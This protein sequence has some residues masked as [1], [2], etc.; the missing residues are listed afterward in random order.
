[1][2]QTTCA[3]AV[4]HDGKILVALPTNGSYRH[5]W[6][7]P[8]GIMD[9]GETHAQA[10]LRECWEETG[11]DFRDREAELID[12]GLHAYRPHKD[13]HLSV[14]HVDAPIDTKTCVCES[15]FIHNEKEYPE[16]SHFAF[17][18]IDIAVKDYL[19]RGQSLLV[20]KLILNSEKV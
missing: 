12:L 2:K 17:V 18:P 1:M 9:P 11:N 8:K 19:N 3:L 16:V 14:L 20:E 10:A 7:L 15:M 4:I 5:G 6:S 13:Y